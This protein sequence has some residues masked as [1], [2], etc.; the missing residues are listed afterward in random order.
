M[1]DIQRNAKYKLDDLRE[2][3]YPTASEN[4][5]AFNNDVIN[6]LT[7]PPCDFEGIEVLI[8]QHLAIEQV[9]WA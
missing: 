2:V 7:N 1:S 9:P 4:I 8:T 3:V 5:I 6:M